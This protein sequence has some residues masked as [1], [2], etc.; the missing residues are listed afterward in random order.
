MS[1]QPPYPGQEW[2]V[3]EQGS[4]AVAPFF[5]RFVA[6]LLDWIL[7][8]FIAIG[9]FGVPWAATGAESFVVLGIFAAE[10][11]VLISTLGST[12]GHKAMGLRVFGYSPGMNPWTQQRPPRPE[13]VL[14]RTALLCL[15]IPALV[16]DRNNRG[17]HDKFGKSVILRVR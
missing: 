15:A 11:V 12:V 3:P 17:M 4:G 6:I 5:R 9:V 1:T 13:G 2:G 14:I 10:N 16:T 8:Q 7:C